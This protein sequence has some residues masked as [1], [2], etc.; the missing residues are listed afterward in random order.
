MK[1]FID[2]FLSITRTHPFH[3]AFPKRIR[4]VEAALEDQDGGDEDERYGWEQS[5][6]VGEQGNG[7]I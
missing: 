5:E 2:R 7:M 3:F 4:Q 6:G 1:F